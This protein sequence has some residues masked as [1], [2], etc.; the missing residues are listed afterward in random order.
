MCRE[1]IMNREDRREQK[2]MDRQADKIH[3]FLIGK[4]AP[5]TEEW[6]KGRNK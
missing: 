5:T 3:S 2:K 1:E 4:L 6:I